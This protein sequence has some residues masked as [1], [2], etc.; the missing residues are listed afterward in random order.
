MTA[1]L[2]KAAEKGGAPALLALLLWQTEMIRTELVEQNAQIAVVLDRC[3]VAG[4]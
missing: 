3:T 1:L 2:V 4:R